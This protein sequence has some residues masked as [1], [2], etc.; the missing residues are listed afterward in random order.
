MIKILLSAGEASGDLHAAALTKAILALEPTAEIYGMGGEAMRAAGGEVVFD[1]KD[2]GVMGIVEVIRKLPQLYKLKK[3]FRKLMQDRRPDCFVTIDYPD[4]NMR[5]ASMAKEMGIPI[6]AY[7]APSAWVWRK[8]RARDVAKLVNKVASIFPFE[9]DLYKA[10]GADVEFVGHPLVD[11][12]KLHIS[13]TA[14]K[15]KAGK[16]D[17]H[18]LILLL[19]GSR[20]KEI[21]NMLPPMLKA[22]KIIKAKNPGVDFVVPRASTIPLGMLKELI[23]VAGVEVHI[24]EGDTY[25]IMSVADVALATSGTVTLEAALCGL[26]SVICYK[27]S[28]ITVAIARCLVRI[29][30]IG[31]PNIVAGRQILPELIQEEMT[32]DNMAKEVLNF[33]EPS[34][35]AR[36]RKELKDVVKKLG[37]SGAVERVAKLILKQAGEHK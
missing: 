37:K 35:H 12:V 30:H 7:I 16:R 8:G 20:I 31:L 17:G 33:L 9:Y 13:E 18:P 25:D 1:I 4:F 23:A 28:A 27:T 3:D 26:P 21:K 32:P 29:P 10:A 36:I 5:I 24:V 6:V 2:H 19:P 14:A 15:A 22:L 11:I 34:E